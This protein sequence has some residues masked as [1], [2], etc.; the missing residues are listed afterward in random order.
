MEQKELL[1]KIDDLVKELNNRSETAARQGKGGF[2]DTKLFAKLETYVREAAKDNLKI[3][4]E[5]TTIEEP[6]MVPWK[7][8]TYHT[9]KF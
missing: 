3:K 5:V 1:Q 4:L 7:L 9:F 8:F 6:D 2:V